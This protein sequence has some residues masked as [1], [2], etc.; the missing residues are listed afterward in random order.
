MSTP[1]PHGGG[2]TLPQAQLEDLSRTELIELARLYARLFSAMDGFWYLA[3]MEFMGEDAATSADLW[4]WD[5]YAR[6]ELKRLLPL[7]KLENNDLAS[8]ARVFAFSPW[9]SNLKH[10][11]TRD[12]TNRLT[13][14]VLDCPS[15]E[16]M[17]RGPGKREDLLQPGRAAATA[18]RC[19]GLQP[20]GESPSGGLTPQRSR[21]RYLLP[22]AVRL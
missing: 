1:A 20:R 6:Y 16:A 21:R 12:G 22:L 15:L 9:F 3:A 17:K 19:P 2:H 5:K 18:H 7:L 10:T 14:T 4:V 11:F 8:F 13:L